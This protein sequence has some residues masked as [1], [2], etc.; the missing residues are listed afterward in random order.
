M[1]D[2]T[3]P[4][5]AVIKDLHPVIAEIL[6]TKFNTGYDILQNVNAYRYLLDEMINITAFSEAEGIET[7]D[8]TLVPDDLP[9]FV[10]RIYDAEP[11][12]IKPVLV[13][14][15]GGNWIAGNLQTSDA[16][17]RTFAEAS[18]CA[19]ISVDYAL[20]PE[21]HFPIPVYQGLAV[22]NWIKRQGHY[23]GINYHKIVIGGDNAGGNIAA[24]LIHLLNQK[25]SVKPIGQL[26]ICPA[27][28]YCF[29][30]PSYNE[31]AQGCMISKEQMQYSWQA[32]LGDKGDGNNKLASPFLATDLK[33]I[34]AS[35]IFTAGHDPLRDEAELYAL[36]LKN[37]GVPV[38]AHRFKS[39]THHFWLMDG[40]LNISRRAQR[41]AIEWLIEISESSEV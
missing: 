29:D 26:L 8:V 30:T 1:G 32:Y 7:C 10:L 38:F 27:L 40:I 15:H 24:G 34:P 12:R 17:C 20:A 31:Y 14:F 39:V 36:R 2:T 3:T 21:H 37:A 16:V 11:D 5:K 22:I 19:V 33:H 4:P 28:Q 6:N 13:Y 23:Y 9:G 18:G 25:K 35:L 41:E